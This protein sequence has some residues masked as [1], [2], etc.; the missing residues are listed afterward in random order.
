MKILIRGYIILVSLLSYSGILMAYEGACYCG[1]IK[2]KTI[3]EP[4][5]TQYCHCHKCRE[6]A[7][8][9]SNKVDKAGFSHTAAY[10]AKNFKI[11]CGQE[12]INVIVRNNSNLI[13][14]KMCKSLIYGMSQDLKNQSG[15]G[16]N[17]NNFIF[18]GELPASF[19]SD[20]HIWY[21]E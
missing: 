13:C 7:S 11:V 2:F 18:L 15:I 19:K 3:G 16:L 9:S 14:C 17:V 8:Q 20:K 10:L 5:F 12:F 1:K 4:I 6:I 21:Q